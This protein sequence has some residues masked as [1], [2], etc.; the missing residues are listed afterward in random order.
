MAKEKGLK[1]RVVSLPS[2]A[3][4]LEQP[5]PYRESVIAPR[6]P[7]FGLTAGLPVTLADVVG[8]LGFVAGLDRF[9]ASAPYKVLDE[10]FGFTAAKV[11]ARIYAYLACYEEMRRKLL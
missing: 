3:L 2:T 5:E 4:F 1:A 11:T 7:V 10:K 8:P 9:G 6:T